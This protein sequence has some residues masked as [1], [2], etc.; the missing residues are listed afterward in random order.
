M[1][2]CSRRALLGAGLVFS[3]A[4]GAFATTGVRADVSL[5]ALISDNM[6]VQ[7]KM[8]VHIY[9]MANVGEK[10]TVSLAGKSANATT[11]ADGKWD[12]YLPAVKAGGPYTL[13]VKGNNT[14]TVNNVLSGEVW[15]CSGQSNMEFAMSRALTGQE[16]IASSANP[17][18]HL[19][20]VNKVRSDTPLPDVKA[21]WQECGPLTVGNFS[22]VGYFFGR[23]LQKNLNVPIGLIESDWG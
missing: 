19:F 4:A 22:A 5:P 6:I 17:N 3:V 14:V 7:Q 11:G 10:V 15:V 9:G 21:T 12:V 8:P 1:G 20:H 16:G 13:V 23:D 2:F 18:I